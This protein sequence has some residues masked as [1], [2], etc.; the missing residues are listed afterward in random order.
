MMSTCI[1][2]LN[3][4]LNRFKVK[5]TAVFFQSEPSGGDPGQPQQSGVRA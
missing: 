4:T 2:I 3:K 5:S 1:L